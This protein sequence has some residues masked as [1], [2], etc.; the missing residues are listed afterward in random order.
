MATVQCT[1]QY[2]LSKVREGINIRSGAPLQLF[3][4]F[5]RLGEFPVSFTIS[6][7]I[8]ARREQFCCPLC[9]VAGSGKL[10]IFCSAEFS[11]ICNQHSTLFCTEPAARGT[12]IRPFVR[13]C[14]LSGAT[15]SLFPDPRGELC[16]AVC[17]ATGDSS[18]HGRADALA[19]PSL[20][21][22]QQHLASILPTL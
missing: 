13:L 4:D 3:F 20:F 10:H 18:L 17:I 1:V 8:K 22:R 15:L 16:T 9:K 21:P 19:L 6:T 7:L 12:G 14:I 5:K 11:K 2:N